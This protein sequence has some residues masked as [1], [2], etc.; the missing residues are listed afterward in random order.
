MPLL[1]KSWYTVNPLKVYQLPACSDGGEGKEGESCL[2]RWWGEGPKEFHRKPYSA[3]ADGYRDPCFR[4]EGTF[5]TNYLE[6]YREKFSIYIF[7]SCD[8]LSKQQS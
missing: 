6:L 4:Q 1:D 5:V 7:S 2:A 3:V 8:D